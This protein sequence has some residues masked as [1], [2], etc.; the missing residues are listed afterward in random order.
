VGTRLTSPRISEGTAVGKKNTSRPNSWKKWPKEPGL[1]IGVP[2]IETD[3]SD[4]FA[5]FP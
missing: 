2:A 1:R 4:L 5:V 3:L